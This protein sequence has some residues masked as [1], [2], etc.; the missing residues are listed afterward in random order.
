MKKRSIYQ[1]KRSTRWRVLCGQEEYT[2]GVG[3]VL[4]VK[5]LQIWA[6]KHHWRLSSVQTGGGGLKGGGKE[7]GMKLW[8]ANPGGEALMGIEEHYF[9]WDEPKWGGDGVQKLI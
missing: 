4:N 8:I 6:E 2:E 5:E 3:A 1:Q 9:S 7:C